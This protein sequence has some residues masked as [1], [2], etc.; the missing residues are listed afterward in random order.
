MRNYIK[1]LSILPGRL[2]PQISTLLAS[3]VSF[4]DSIK[5][6]ISVA[7]LSKRI[8]RKKP[9]EWAEIHFE[10][11]QNYITNIQLLHRVAI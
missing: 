6:S 10:I 5:K 8:E 3:M 9:E 2:N 4:R 11:I 1:K 7:I